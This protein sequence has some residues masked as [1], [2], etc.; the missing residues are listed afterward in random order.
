MR[1]RRVGGAAPRSQPVTPG[2]GALSPADAPVA[3]PSEPPIAMV[4]GQPISQRRV[5]DVLLSSHGVGILEQLIGLETAREAAGKRGLRVSEQDVEAE[6]DLAL[7]RLLDPTTRD[8]KGPFDREAAERVLGD[9]L[10]DRNISRREY[11]VIVE[12][13]AYLRKLVLSDQR[14]SEEQLEAEY[15]NTFGER[16]VVRQIQ[17]ATLGEVN[18]VREALSQGQD[19]GTLAAAH[20]ANRATAERM[21]LME[22][23]SA[24]D[25]RLP[26]AFRKAAFALEPGE[27]SDA[28]RIGEWFHLIRLEER[29]A[30]EHRPMDEVREELEQRLRDRLT[31]PAMFALYEKLFEAATIEVYDPVLREA[32]LGKHPGRTR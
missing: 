3:S 26:E 12:R 1:D 32:F 11:R 21:G 18:R 20:S 5:M 19:F 17:L 30:P 14:F 9:V 28:V 22:P 23:F 2:G 24:N 31:D 8:I 25:E 16:I 4:N 7:R 29:V 27:V 10:A 13:N 15:K 6:Y